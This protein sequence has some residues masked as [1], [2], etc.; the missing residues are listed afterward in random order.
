MLWA[1]ASTEVRNVYVMYVAGEA[2]TANVKAVLPRGAGCS[3][4]PE[5]YTL[6]ALQLI[7]SSALYIRV[8][9]FA[10]TFHDTSP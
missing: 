1:R 3:E 6:P 8:H 10:V 9:R 5:C 4:S 2:S 7:S